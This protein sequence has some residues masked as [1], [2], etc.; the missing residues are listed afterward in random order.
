MRRILCFLFSVLS[1]YFANQSVVYAGVPEF[2]GTYRYR[3]QFKIEGGQRED[4]FIK[5]GNEARIQL[6]QQQGF[7]C[8]FTESYAYCNKAFN[9]D[10]DPQIAEALLYLYKDFMVLADSEM[11][12]AKLVSDQDGLQMYTRKQK[13]ICD[14][15]VIPQI[16]LS[17]LNQT[18]WLSVGPSE[19]GVSFDF[20]L[21][22]R[23]ELLHLR[24][25][26]LRDEDMMKTVYI[27]V[28]LSKN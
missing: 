16:S 2:V 6:R 18:W 3:G 7:D 28:E 14:S 24:K 11:E 25:L 9:T 8:Q 1:I 20:K 12:S 10:S 26:H 19:N 22:T 15:L 4:V 27:L 5:F 13:W 23:E 17:N 21:G